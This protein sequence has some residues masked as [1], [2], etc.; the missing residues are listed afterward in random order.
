MFELHIVRFYFVRQKTNICD[1]I[2]Q[3]ESE[4]GSDMLLVSDALFRLNIRK[5]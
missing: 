1:I 4:V 5:C 2:K 3:N